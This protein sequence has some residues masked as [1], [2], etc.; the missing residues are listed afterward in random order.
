[1]QWM[2]VRDMVI[3]ETFEDFYLDLISKLTKVNDDTI[4]LNEDLSRIMFKRE[5][6]LQ[7]KRD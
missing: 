5:E 6:S 4:C 3:F 1:M 2:A 7:I